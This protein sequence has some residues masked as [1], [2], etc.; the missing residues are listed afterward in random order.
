MISFGDILVIIFIRLLVFKNKVSTGNLYLVIGD[1]N[2]KIIFL[3]FR[4][5][6]EDAIGD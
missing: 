1:R 2:N 6:P 3:Q 5:N 4:A